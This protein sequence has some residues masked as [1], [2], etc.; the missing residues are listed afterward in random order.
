MNFETQPNSGQNHGLSAVAFSLQRRHGC[1]VVG[2]KNLYFTRS[3]L[4]H[5]GSLTSRVIGF[6]IQPMQLEPPGQTKL[7]PSWLRQGHFQRSHHWSGLGMRFC[8]FRLI[9]HL[10]L[11]LL[12]YPTAT[13]GYKSAINAGVSLFWI[14]YVRGGLCKQA[15]THDSVRP[16]YIP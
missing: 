11:K 7:M 5:G 4:H 14:P 16:G 15:C 8:H 9:L 13:S 6:Y 3:L 12:G 1:G 2:T 10:A